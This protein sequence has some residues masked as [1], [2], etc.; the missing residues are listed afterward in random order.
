MQRV[1]P[2]GSGTNVGG[3]RLSATQPPF[4][5][6]GT[7]VALVEDLDHALSNSLDQAL[8]ELDR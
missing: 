4:W 5:L 3:D 1:D 7:P 2:G 8:G 6:T